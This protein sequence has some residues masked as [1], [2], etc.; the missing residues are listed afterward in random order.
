[1]TQQEQL[2]DWFIR[3]S[4]IL[5]KRSTHRQKERFLQAFQTDVNAIRDD[6]NV[7]EFK[8]HPKDPYTYHNVYVGDMHRA[9]Q[10]ICTYYDTPT[11]V[12]RDYAYFDIKQHEQSTT[13]LI[14]FTALSYIIAGGLFTWLVTI[15]MLA[16]GHLISVASILMVVG[17]LAY[18]L[19]LGQMTRGWPS[20]HTLIQNSSSLVALLGILGAQRKSTVAFAF[21]DAGCTNDAGLKRVLRRKKGKCRFFMVENIG[22]DTPLY[23]ITN[24]TVHQY[25]DI[26]GFENTT[27]VMEMDDRITYLISAKKYGDRFVLPLAQLRQKKINTLNMEVL[28]RFIESL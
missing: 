10:I 24:D 15:P 11:V 14:M 7:D 21:V 27:T 13:W 9:T 4:S 3:Y 6:F 26:E 19:M 2:M 16:G 22:G 20:R 17:Y 25:R 1:M 8:L 5:K 12:W 28:S 18:F 23:A